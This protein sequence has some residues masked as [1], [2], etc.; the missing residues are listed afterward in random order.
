MTGL[1]YGLTV[2]E[3]GTQSRDCH[4]QIVEFIQMQLYM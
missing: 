1:T 3:K 2:L 4:I